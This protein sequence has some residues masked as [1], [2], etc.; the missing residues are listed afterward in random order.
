[1]AKNK[2]TGKPQ[3]RPKKAMK[4]MKAMKAKATIPTKR[5]KAMKAMKARSTI[6]ARSITIAARS[7]ATSIKPTY[8]MCA[9]CDKRIY[10][11]W[12]GQC[13]TPGCKGYKSITTSPGDLWIMATTDVAGNPITLEHLL[14]RP[15]GSA[16]AMH[17]KS[18]IM[19]PVELMSPIESESA[20]SEIM[21]PVEL[22]S[23]MESESMH[24]SPITEDSDVELQSAID[25]WVASN[26]AMSPVTPDS[27]AEAITA[28]DDSPKSNDSKPVWLCASCNRRPAVHWLGYD[29]CPE[30]FDEH[31]E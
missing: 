31:T 29:E 26:V 11:K 15:Q 23:P 5:I 18:E 27:D 8:R 13:R 9:G 3:P 24:V 21:S 10:G 7:V 30:C 25:K 16:T 14:G 4:A 20:K 1:M 28:I 6:P 17:A 19:S 2:A 12:L 22:M